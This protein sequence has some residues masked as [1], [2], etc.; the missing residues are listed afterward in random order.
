MGI[1]MHGKPYLTVGD[2]PLDPILT[3]YS[4]QYKAWMK[5]MTPYKWTLFRLKEKLEKE[6]GSQLLLPMFS[7]F[8]KPVYPSNTY[9]K[10][11]E[12]LKAQLCNQLYSTLTNTTLHPD[13][14]TSDSQ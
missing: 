2:I 10:R 11:V 7:D 6:N 12:E 8:E 5:T 3:D 4:V 13:S 9:W 1:D 14:Q